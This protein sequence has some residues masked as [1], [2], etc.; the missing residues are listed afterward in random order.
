SALGALVSYGP[1]LA[2]LYR[3]AASYHVDRILR[4]A[5]PADLPVEGPTVFDLI[6]NRTTA[7]ALGIVIPPEFAVQV[8]EWLTDG[9]P[10][11]LERE[12]HC[13]VPR[14]RPARSRAT[15]PRALGAPSARPARC[16]I[17]PT[18]AAVSACASASR[19]SARTAPPSLTENKESAMTVPIDD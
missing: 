3:R 16:S 12:R 4:G 10:E 2:P 1:Q 19:P 7:R 13:Q 11:K 8:T 15:W 9:C 17:V 5:K 18:A 14:I 6:V